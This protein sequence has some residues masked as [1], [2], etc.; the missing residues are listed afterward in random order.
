M[1]HPLRDPMYTP[2]FTPPT[3]AT[4][5]APEAVERMRYPPL[6]RT[7]IEVARLVSSG[8]GDTS[9]LSAVVHMD[10]VVAT[11]VLRRV[12]SAHFGLREQVADISV[13][14]FLLGFNEVCNIVMTEALLKL[15]AIARTDEQMRIFE[16]II[17]MS[18]G[19]ASFCDYLARSLQLPLATSAYTAGLLHTTGRLVLLYNRPYDYEAL[20]LTSGNPGGPE[21]QSEALI[22]GADHEELGLKAT[23]FWNFPEELVALVGHYTQPEYASGARYHA[24]A[25]ALHTSVAAA[26]SVCTAEGSILA[27]APP[28]SAERFASAARATAAEIAS[29]ID[30]HTPHVRRLVGE[31][32]RPGLDDAND[33]E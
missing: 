25:L 1:P 9:K 10:P 7:V 2:R 12:N 17:C 20:W 3:P 33:Q 5:L 4:R 32:A 28:D 21:R 8:S 23:T 6:P 11:A 18:V 16:Q 19:A 26:V 22:F 29:L 27:F 14:V 15:R 13:A 30:D 31:I 24:M